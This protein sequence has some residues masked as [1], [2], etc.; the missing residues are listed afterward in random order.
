LD[1]VTA[2]KDALRDELAAVLAV[3][4]E[5]AEY[6][7]RFLVRLTAAGVGQPD[8]HTGGRKLAD[9]VATFIK[10]YNAIRRDQGGQSAPDDYADV[11]PL[12]AW[13]E[14]PHH[15]A[16]VEVFEVEHPNAIDVCPLPPSTDIANYTDDGHRPALEAT[17]RE[18]V[19]AWSTIIGSWCEREGEDLLPIYRAVWALLLSH[20]MQP[21]TSNLTNLEAIEVASP[22]VANGVVRLKDVA[23][24]PR[25]Q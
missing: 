2:S 6:E 8:L 3:P 24:T 22:W 16:G 25:P 7:R 19:R 13:S 17:R 11:L 10:Q 23:G 12:S 9:A 21:D 18:T 15:F 1:D 14:L 20:Y 4:D 5:V